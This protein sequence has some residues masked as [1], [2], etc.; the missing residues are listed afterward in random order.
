MPEFQHSPHG[1]RV[2][3]SRPSCLDSLRSQPPQSQTSVEI[4]IYFYYTLITNKNSVTSMQGLVKM[5][6]NFAKQ[7]MHRNAYNNIKQGSPSAKLRRR[8]IH[9]ARENLF[10]INVSIYS[11]KPGTFF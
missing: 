5:H 3:K 8:G 10:F 4:Y 1:E 9:T 6:S 2:E 7:G 11:V